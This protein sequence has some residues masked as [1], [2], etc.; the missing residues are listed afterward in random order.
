[1]TAYETVFSAFRDKVT[2]YDYV[3]L[4]NFEETEILV[5]LMNKATAIFGRVCKKLANRSNETEEFSEDLT[6]E[7]INILTEFMV[8]YWLKPKLYHSENLQNILSTK[9][10]SFYSPANLLSQIRTLH[11]DANKSARAMMNEYSILTSNY[12][13]IRG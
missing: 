1:M 9:D 10:F 8:V 6:D 4:S 7:E 12:E 13:N 5:G 11:S 2:D 3:D